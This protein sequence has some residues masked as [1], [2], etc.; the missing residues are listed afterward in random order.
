MWY[1]NSTDL[2]CVNFRSCENTSNEGITWGQLKS[3]EHAYNNLSSLCQ[4]SDV[5]P[6][7]D[8]LH[9]SPA[10]SSVHG[11]L[12]ARILEWVAIFSLKGSYWSR[13]QTCVSCT[14]GRYFTTE[15]SE[16]PGLSFIVFYCNS[17]PQWEKQK[18]YANFLFIVHQIC[19]QRK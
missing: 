2:S 5:S 10:G 19:K 17:S 14:A 18:F 1:T 8:H 9:C 15:P 6:L 7:S 11:I 4:R 16:K 12:Q 13:D 3:S